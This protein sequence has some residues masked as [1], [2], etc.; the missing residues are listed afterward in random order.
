MTFVYEKENNERLSKFE[1][2]VMDI[3]SE[4]EEKINIASLKDIDKVTPD[5]LKKAASHLKIVRQI[6]LIP[7][8]LI[9]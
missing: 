7:I 8:L 6:Q 4:H 5:I 1:M 2:K 3:E 9:A